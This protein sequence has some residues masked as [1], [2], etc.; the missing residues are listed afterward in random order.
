MLATYVDL[1]AFRRKSTQT[2]VER[3]WVPEQIS[4]KGGFVIVHLPVNGSKL[5]AKENI[6]AFE[7]DR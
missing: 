6:Y 7:Q 5:A 2:Q 1:C 3:H 4:Y